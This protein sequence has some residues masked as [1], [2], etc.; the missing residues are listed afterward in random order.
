M[1][2]ED[3]AEGNWFASIQESFPF[4]FDSID[5]NISWAMSMWGEIIFSVLILFGL[6]TRFAAI[7]LI[8][9][10]VVATAA[11]HWPES[12]N[13]LSELWQ[14]YAISNKGFG[15]YKLPL[16]YVIMLLP[17]L[18]NGA[19]KLSL[20]HLLSKIMTGTD[21]MQQKS[22]LGMWG[23]ALM[24]L[25]V[26]LMFVMPYFG[27]AVAAFGFVGLIANKFLKT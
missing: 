11:V 25:G 15:H 24:A 27:G 1:K 7:S 5:P 13:T 18:F 6:F 12:W 21:G 23:L 3:G 4:P 26:P 2:Y 9:I 17:L 14:G 20:D 19:G 22:D 10:T 16:I 8:M